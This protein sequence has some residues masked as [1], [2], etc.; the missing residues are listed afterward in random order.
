MRLLHV[1][2]GQNS[3]L[4]S[5]SPALASLG[6]D[7]RSCHYVAAAAAPGQTQRLA[8]LLLHSRMGP[9]QELQPPPRGVGTNLSPR[10]S[11]LSSFS[12]KTNVTA[13]AELHSCCRDECSDRR[14]VAV[15]P[16]DDLGHLSSRRSLSSSPLRR[17]LARDC[18]S[19][20][21]LAA[22]SSRAM[23]RAL[24]SARRSRSAMRRSVLSSPSRPSA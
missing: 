5:H 23:I 18:P 16:R 10:S 12:K 1:V 24:S 2:L 11:S 6:K 9:P 8:D 14:L 20:R 22:T 3:L 19:V 15:T 17:A 7:E 13:A 4:S 21:S